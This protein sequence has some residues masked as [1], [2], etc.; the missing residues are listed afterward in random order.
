MFIFSTIVTHCIKSLPMSSLNQFWADFTS[1]YW[2]V[3]AIK[4]DGIKTVNRN[5]PG[6]FYS[7][8]CLWDLYIFDIKISGGFRALNS[9]AVI[10]PNHLSNGSK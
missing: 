8:L 5:P 6:H 4:T 3:I 7:N 2:L 1:K 9:S 10:S